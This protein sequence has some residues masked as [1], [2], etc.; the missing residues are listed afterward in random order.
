MPAAY[1]YCTITGLSRYL[2]HH[3]STAMR[4]SFTEPSCYMWMKYWMDSRSAVPWLRLRQA[5]LATMG[6]ICFCTAHPMANI[7]AVSLL[8]IWMIRDH[9]VWQQFI[10]WHMSKSLNCVYIY[11]I[12]SNKYQLEYIHL[13]FMQYSPFPVW[14]C[15]RTHIVRLFSTWHSLIYTILKY[16]G[17]TLP[18]AHSQI[19]NRKLY[20]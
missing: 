3:W 12:P 5:T 9:F 2:T 17:Q 10:C 6:T 13:L 19:S 16:I 4:R 18:R 8:Y 1:V 15:A 20:S 7:I 11:L 14:G